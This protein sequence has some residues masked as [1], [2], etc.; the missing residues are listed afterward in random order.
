MP[1]LLG[2][3]GMDMRSLRRAAP[4][5]LQI[6]RKIVTVDDQNL[7][8]VRGD[9]LGGEQ[10]GQ[11]AT[12]DHDPRQGVGCSLCSHPVASEVV[13]ES[14]VGNPVFGY[15]GDVGPSVVDDQ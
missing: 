1:A 13:L 2:Q 3:D 15:G 8:G 7:P 14:N 5:R 10:S 4:G 6:V 9:H 12:Q 11:A